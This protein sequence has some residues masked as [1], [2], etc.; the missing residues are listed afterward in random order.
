[1]SVAWRKERE[2]RPVISPSELS[3]RLGPTRKGVKALVLGVGEDVFELNFPYISLEKLRPSSV[4][5]LWT[6]E[7]SKRVSPPGAA[8]ESAPDAPSNAP[9]GISGARADAIRKL[10]S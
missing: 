5:A 4:P 2:R 10:N 3:T 8:V 6:R 9:K 7:V 1:M